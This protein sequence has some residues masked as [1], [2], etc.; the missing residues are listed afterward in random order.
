M[1]RNGIGLDCTKE[2][3]L[4]G[5]HKLNGA[6]HRAKQGKTSKFRGVSR[7]IGR[8]K[9]WQAF[10]MVGGES[11]YLGRFDTEEQAAKAYNQNALLHF[12]EHASL[13]KV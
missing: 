13:N 1:H 4:F 9:K 6:S 2:N 12:G 11:K 10:I 8:G 5:T 7:H 3:L